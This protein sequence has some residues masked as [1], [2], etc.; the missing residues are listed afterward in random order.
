MPDPL[1]HTARLG[2]RARLKL[3]TH[4]LHRSAERSGIMQALLHGR[5]ERAQYCLL[6][7]SLYELYAGLEGALETHFNH[8]QLA[9]IIFRSMFRLGALESD[10]QFFAGR[11]WSESLAPKPAAVAYRRRLDE[12][13]DVRPGLLAAHAYTRYLYDLGGG[14]IIARLVAERL[15]VGD[16]G[17]RFFQFGAPADI[18]VLVAHFRAGLDA[19]P[20]D[21][22]EEDAIVEEA[23]DALRRHIELYRQ[24]A[25]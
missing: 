7:R 20:A 19:I 2:L 25:V 24:L 15:R 10:L 23:Q 6:L 14:Q 22:A 8:P 18:D 1:S 9:P 16:D 12:L 5:V 3:E 13:A 4:E 11:E 21:P 17:T